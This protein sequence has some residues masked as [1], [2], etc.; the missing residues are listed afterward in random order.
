MKSCISSCPCSFLQVTKQPV[1][2]SKDNRQAVAEFQGQFMN[3]TDLVNMF[4]RYVTGYEAGTD[5]KVTVWH[6]EHEE[7]SGGI[8]AELDIQ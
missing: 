1:R 6:G 5:D 2:R 8:E 4:K 3:S 7:N